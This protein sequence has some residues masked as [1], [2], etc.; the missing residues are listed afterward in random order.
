MK[1]VMLETIY[2]VISS[3]LTV[4]SFYILIA[5]IVYLIRKLKDDLKVESTVVSACSL[6]S[7]LCSVVVTI[8]YYKLRNTHS[9]NK[10]FCRYVRIH[11][12]CSTVLSKCFSNLVFVYR[13]KI[14]NKTLVFAKRAYALTVTIIH[15]MFIGLMSNLYLRIS[16]DNQPCN[17]DR[18]N[19]SHY[20]LSNTSSY[21]PI[22]ISFCSFIITTLLQTIILVEIVKPVYL[23]YV[24]TK[25]TT[26]PNDRTKKLLIRVIFTTLSFSVSD[27]ALVVYGIGNI[28]FKRRGSEIY[29]LMVSN[30]II[31]TVS[32]MC[33][34]ADCRKRLF[35][36]L[37]WRDRIHRNTSFLNFL[38]ENVLRCK[39]SNTNKLK[40]LEDYQKHTGLNQNNY[41]KVSLKKIKCKKSNIKL[42]L[43][44]VKSFDLPKEIN[45]NIF[46][47]VMI[48]ETKTLDNVPNVS[49]K[50]TGPISFVNEQATNSKKHKFLAFVP[51]RKN[52]KE[53]ETTV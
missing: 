13:Y 8:F 46:A 10:S 31:N 51:R 36:F 4:L 41:D 14:I 47:N 21:F 40:N 24:K 43:N 2:L 48:K 53:F 26:I 25:R 15:W 42:V 44:N 39:D 38:N 29:L 3:F 30:L 23:H 16:L 9:M 33:T 1:T 34:Y 19:E 7:F 17:L 11:A 45:Q 49:I 22:T 6:C 52:L 28:L 27:F 50:R 18:Q 35:P 5:S 20:G 12:V 32:L 37:K